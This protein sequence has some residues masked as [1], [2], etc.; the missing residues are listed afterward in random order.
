MN[1]FQAL[2]ESCWISAFQVYKQT[3]KTVFHYKKMTMLR[4]FNQTIKN[5]LTLSQ[6]T[7]FR[8]SKIER[9]WRRQ[10]EVWRKWWTVPQQS[11]KPCGKWRNCLVGAISSFPTLFSKDLYCKHIKSRHCLGQ[12]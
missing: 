5:I 4:F 8:V 7:N 6:M 3:R 11:R 1:L 2:V 12:G 9:F 10:F